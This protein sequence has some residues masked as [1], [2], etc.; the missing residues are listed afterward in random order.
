MS[1]HTP[2]PWKLI[3]TKDPCSVSDWH[4]YT[5][6][7]SVCVFPYKRIY[8]EDRKQSGLVV[9]NESMANAVLMTASPDLLQA[10]QLVVAHIPE[11]IA[12]GILTAA[13]TDTIRAAITKAGD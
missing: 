5:G 12:S 9:C 8:S 2:G 11:I 13:E 10:L 1:K 6:A 7:D 4:I 3:E